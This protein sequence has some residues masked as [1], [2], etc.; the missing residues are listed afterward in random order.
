M[1][2]LVSA[3]A[4][5]AAAIKSYGVF[6]I[7]LMALTFMLLAWIVVVMTRLP[8]SRREWVVSLISTSVGSIAGGGFVIQHFDL[9]DWSKNMFGVF[10]LGG[11]YFLCGLPVWALIRWTFNYINAREDLTILDVAREV[12]DFKDKF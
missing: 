1:V 9:Q 6:F 12:K 11:L 7:I 2:D 8:K 3:G 5:I 4:D 10:A